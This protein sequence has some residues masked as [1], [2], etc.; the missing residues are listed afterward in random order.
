MDQKIV[1]KFVSKQ[2]ELQM[3]QCKMC[4]PSIATVDIVLSRLFPNFSKCMYATKYHQSSSFNETK[5]LSILESSCEQ[6]Q[7]ERFPVPLLGNPVFGR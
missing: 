3:A 7:N 5:H 4:A 6:L 1:L 2:W